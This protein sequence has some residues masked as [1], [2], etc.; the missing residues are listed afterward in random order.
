[1]NM[2]LQLR[3]MATNDMIEFGELPAIIG[4][5]ATAD[6]QLDDP[7]LPPFQ[8]MIGEEADDGA[9]V[10]NLRNDFPLY[11]NGRQVM[12]ADLLHGDI[13]TIGQNRFAF[14]CEAALHRPLMLV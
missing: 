11:V 2:R 7:T 3:E 10:L 5:D 4:R 8:C 12:R 6:I 9:F 13:L 1:M 14:L